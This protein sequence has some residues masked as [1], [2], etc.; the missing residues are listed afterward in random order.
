MATTITRIS[1]SDSLA[2]TATRIALDHYGTFDTL[3]AVRDGSGN[4][5]LIAWRTGQTTSRL[6]DSGDQAGAVSEI[7]LTRTANL[8][9]TAVRAGNDTLKLISW[10][11]GN[12][13]DSIVRQSDSGDQAGEATLIGAQSIGSTS[14]ADVVTPVRT[15]GG[16]LKLI[17]WNVTN[18]GLPT[19][20]SKS[21]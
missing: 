6:A 1:D 21:T 4:L 20:S 19:I 5:K 12:Q 14:N 3:S 10:S 15:A 13:L 9:V 8:A 18:A 2:G 7:A 11:T 17:S 16:S